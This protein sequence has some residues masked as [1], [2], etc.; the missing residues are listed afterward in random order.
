MTSNA[1]ARKLHVPPAGS[2][3]V[4]GAP[5]GYI[6]SLGAEAPEVEAHAGGG[7][8]FVQVFA[9]DTV[10]LERRLPSALAALAPGGVLWMTYPKQSSGLPTDLTRD[11][12][13]EALRAHGW[14]PVSQV[15]IDGVW[16]A[17][18]F[19]PVASTALG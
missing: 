14:R 17:L 5:E 9:H 3:V 15:A 18:R 1:L 13:W 19:R 7:A 2:I 6:E 10:E 11:R 4:I 16:S 8:A 12:G